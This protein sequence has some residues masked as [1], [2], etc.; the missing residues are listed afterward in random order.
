[1]PEQYPKTPIVTLTTD[2]GWR[3]YYV[4]V[5]KGAILCKNSDTNIVDITHEIENYNIVQAAFVI[6]N[7]WQSF[8]IGTI[9]V[10]SV[11]DFAKYSKGFL[12]IQYG[13]QY[14][15]GPDNG[16]F[17]LIFS[18][19][20][21]RAYRIPKTE[22]SK[23]PLKDIYASAVGHIQQNIPIS[24]IGEYVEDLEQRINLRPV[25]TPSRVQGAVIHIDTF[26]NVIVNIDRQLFEQVGHGRPFNIYFKRHDPINRL[27]K[28]YYDVP[29]GETMAFFNSANYLEIAINMGKAS[30]LLDLKL[31]DSI[32]I[33]FH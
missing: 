25:I 11:N 30:S 14:F 9:H 3:D 29:V 27:S 6:R 17:S 13:G 1:M 24:Q 20:K 22:E 32:Q 21:F 18:D 28:S 31:E 7:A 2:F 33:D 15:I 5:I 10:I 16:I 19:T 8:P 23:F 4:A 12:A 26:E